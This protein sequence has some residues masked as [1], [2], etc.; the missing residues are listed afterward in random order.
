MSPSFT[1][2]DSWDY[3][4]EAEASAPS[5][6]PPP[7]YSMAEWGPGGDAANGEASPEK[8]QT[9]EIGDE[10]KTSASKAVRFDSCNDSFD[11]SFAAGNS[12]PK[13]SRGKLLFV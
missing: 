8:P 13:S 10:P 7:S 4:F 9:L 1:G 3:S 5:E 6:T 12:P 11:A 2:T